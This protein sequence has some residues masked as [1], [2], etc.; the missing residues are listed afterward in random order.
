MY[1]F[2][3]HCFHNILAKYLV[4]RQC[5][6]TKKDNANDTASIICL[7]CS[8]FVLSYFKAA[9]RRLNVDRL[10]RSTCLL[11]PKLRIGLTSLSS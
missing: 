2:I 5:Q 11:Q 3:F 9:F 6:D 1:F 4:S 7:Y 8:E 10:R